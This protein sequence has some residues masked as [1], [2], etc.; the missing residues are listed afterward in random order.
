MCEIVA[1]D[2]FMADKICNLHAIN[3]FTFCKVI[4]VSVKRRLDGKSASR[5]KSKS[6]KVVANVLIGAKHMEPLYQCYI[7]FI[8]YQMVSGLTSKCRFYLQYLN[9]GWL[10][11]AVYLAPLEFGLSQLDN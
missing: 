4:N 7:I 9:R 5:K 6:Q 8:D 2:N 11:E 10:S 3:V 1:S